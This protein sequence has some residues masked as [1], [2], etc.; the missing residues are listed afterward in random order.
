MNN[1]SYSAIKTII[2]YEVKSYFK[3]FQ[4]NIVAP[5]ISTLLF[6]FILS[7]IEK[8]YTFD[9][10]ENS[11][12]NFLVPG[13]IMSVI[14]QT[15][16]NHL[17]EVIITMKQNGS[18]NDYLISPISRIEI[19]FSFIVSSIFVCLIVGIINLLCL[20][21]FTEFTHINYF[22]LIYYLI[23]AIITFSSLG[24]LTGI[25]SFTWDIQSSVSNFF[26]VP[27]S[28]LSGTFFSIDSLNSEIHFIF[29]LN[30]F[31][32]LVSGFR[33]SFAYGYKNNLYYDLY[34]LIILAFIFL[35]TL[36]IFN[37]GYKV[38]N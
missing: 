22:S 38:I 7:T 30:P 20:S 35:L 16:F 14:F 6:V 13:M 28:F 27:T 17:S 9:N 23:I 12:M 29:K 3:E 25:L 34:I 37:K 4:F 1:L 26:I 18:F 36:F 5:L 2:F 21:I 10:S 32:H 11:Y 24:A 8:Y 15:S 31:Y 33:N 19:F